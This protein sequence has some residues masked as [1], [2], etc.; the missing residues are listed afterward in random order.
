[1]TSYKYIT[2]INVLFLLTIE[3]EDGYLGVTFMFR[4]E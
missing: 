4:D 1:M 2:F 3:K